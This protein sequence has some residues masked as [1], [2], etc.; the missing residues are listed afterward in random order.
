MKMVLNGKG[1]REDD[2]TTTRLVLASCSAATC[3]AEGT[4][5][6]RSL[7]RSKKISRAVPTKAAINLCLSVVHVVPASSNSFVSAVEI[8][9]VP[10]RARCAKNSST[11]RGRSE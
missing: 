2:G 4:G 11:R 10:T 5:T 9:L 3:K 6:H 7:G 8:N 1:Q